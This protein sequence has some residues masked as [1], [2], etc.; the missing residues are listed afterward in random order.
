MTRPSSVK[1][2]RRLLWNASIADYR[3]ECVLAEDG[4]ASAVVV[5]ENGREIERHPQDPAPPARTIVDLA[6]TLGERYLPRIMTKAKHHWRVR[7]MGCLTAH[8][9]RFPASRTTEPL[10]D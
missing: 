1:P 5:I 7:G 3:V 4:A 9:L 6:A 10:P 8:G 2:D